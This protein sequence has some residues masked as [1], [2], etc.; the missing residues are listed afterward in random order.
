MPIVAEQCRFVAGVG[1][2]A[3]THALALLDARAGHQVAVA[4]FPATV[5]G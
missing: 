4:T 2:H 3:R 5:A 1:T